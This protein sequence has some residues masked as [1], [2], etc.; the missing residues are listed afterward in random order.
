MVTF[1][2]SDEAF[3]EDPVACFAQGGS[4]ERGNTSEIY[5]DNGKMSVRQFVPDTFHE[6]RDYDGNLLGLSPVLYGQAEAY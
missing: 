5:R 2:N 1:N 6:V 4:N 3:R